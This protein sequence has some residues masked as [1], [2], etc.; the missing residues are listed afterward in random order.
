MSVLKL[1]LY[2]CL[3]VFAENTHAPLRWTSHCSFR[4]A[5]RER[6]SDFSLLQVAK[7]L[8]LKMNEVDFYEPFM[9]EPTPI[10]NKPYS[11]EELVEFVKEHQR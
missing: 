11:E 5:S 8:S 10:P 4:L 3:H 1:E 9:D 2:M 6:L 7:K